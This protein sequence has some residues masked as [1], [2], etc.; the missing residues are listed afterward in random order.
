MTV[1]TRPLT[2]IYMHTADGGKYYPFAPREGD[3]NIEVIAHHLATKG[4]WN[5]ATVHPSDHRRIFYSVAEHSVYV[6]R[7]VEEELKKP[8][9]ALAALLHDAAEAYN[10][11]LIRPLKHS[12]E[13]AAPFKRVEERN[14]QVI[15]QHYGLAWPM[16]K[17]IKIADE[18]VCAAEFEQIVPKRSGHDWNVGLLH[19]QSRVAPY[20]IQMLQPFQAKLRFLQHFER[21]IT[22]MRPQARSA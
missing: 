18:A 17:E 22:A 1:T 20:E 12:P 11:D 15:F 3:V 8:D 19:D 9:I 21:L 4:R 10:G 13:F 2:D 16:A 7:Y 6:A 14:E 5:G